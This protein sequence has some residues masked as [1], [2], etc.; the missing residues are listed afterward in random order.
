MGEGRVDARYNSHHAGSQDFHR[1]VDLEEYE[2]ARTRNDKNIIRDFKREISTSRL[3]RTTDAS[4]VKD[5]WG[6]AF[7]KDLSQTIGLIDGVHVLRC[8]KT[9]PSR[10]TASTLPPQVA[11][12][13]ISIPRVSLL[14]SLHPSHPLLSQLD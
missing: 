2:F 3:Q 10:T 9:N 14:S 11:S 4:R 1:H 12:A 6:A 8:L 13:D 7:H 5:T